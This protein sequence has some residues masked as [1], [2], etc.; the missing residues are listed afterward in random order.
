MGWHA[1][2][3][4]PLR[5]TDASPYPSPCAECKQLRLPLAAAGAAVAL[6]LVAAYRATHR[7]ALCPLLKIVLSPA[8]HGFPLQGC[9]V[10][11]SVFEDRVAC[12]VLEIGPKL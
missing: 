6:N 5:P 10:Q 1:A 7:A 4:W 11:Y 12:C 8:A 3:Q 9:C 2:E